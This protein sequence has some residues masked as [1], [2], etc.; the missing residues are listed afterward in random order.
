MIRLHPPAD[1]GVSYRSPPAHS[2]RLSRGIFT[3]FKGKI[4]H[5]NTTMISGYCMYT[6]HLHVH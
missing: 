1:H 3:Y 2:L 4:P 5:W 6:F